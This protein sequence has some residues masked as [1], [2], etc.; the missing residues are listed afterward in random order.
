MQRGATI[1]GWSLAAIVIGW[2]VYDEVREPDAT[3]DLPFLMAAIVSTQFLALQLFARR[4]EA[5][6]WRVG[7]ELGVGLTVAVAVAALGVGLATTWRPRLR[8]GWGD[9]ASGLVPECVLVLAIWV[10]AFRY[11]T[12]RARAGEAL[13]LAREAELAELRARLQPHFLGNSLNAIASLVR[14]QPERA[15]DLLAELGELLRDLAAEP[16]ASWSLAQEIAWCRRYVA[17]LEARHDGDLACTW[18]LDESALG[19][20]LPTFV[21]QPIVENAVLHSSGAPAPR[22]LSVAVRRTDTGASVTV[23]SS[24]G[25]PRGAPTGAGLALV[26][27][28]L[29]LWNA[30]ATLD[31]G[32]RGGEFVVELA[33]P[34]RAR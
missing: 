1:L 10:V 24:L 9:A 8:Q 25:P 17:L 23:S 4:A 2:F 29:A 12:A 18:A 27:R 16:G 5:R 11:P 7:A 34:E 19:V 26:R 33:L 13:R 22:H 21:L 15:R 3:R 28:R 14:E 31:A 6:G 32:P 20:A 30:H